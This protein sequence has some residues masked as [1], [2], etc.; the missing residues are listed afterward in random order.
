LGPYTARRAASAAAA[1]VLGVSDAAAP[2][3]RAAA[4]PLSWCMSWVLR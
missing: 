4:L 1:A 3:T 2:N